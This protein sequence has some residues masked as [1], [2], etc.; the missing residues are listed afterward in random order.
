MPKETRWPTRLSIIFDLVAQIL[1][2]SSTKAIFTSQLRIGSDESA[3]TSEWGWKASINPSLKSTLG[4]HQPPKA[5]QFV[6]DHSCHMK[7]GTC[8]NEGYY[9]SV[10]SS[11]PFEPGTKLLCTWSLRDF[12]RGFITVRPI[13]GTF[14]EQWTT[15]NQSEN[16]EHFCGKFGELLHDRVWTPIV[17]RM[18][19]CWSPPY[20]Y[21][22]VSS[23]PKVSFSKLVDLTRR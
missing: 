15:A 22:Q 16:S 17:A 5:N 9:D 12:I 20:L 18:V 13:I 4:G 7:D 3:L 14:S 10:S 8:I 21:N 19:K 6:K 2:Q 1:T 11:S 23:H